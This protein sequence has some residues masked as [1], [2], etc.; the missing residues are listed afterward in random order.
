MNYILQHNKD[1]LMV[2]DSIP[3]YSK[4]MSDKFKNSIFNGIL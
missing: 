4:I 1:L 3:F 2:L